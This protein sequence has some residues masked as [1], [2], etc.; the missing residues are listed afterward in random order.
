[1]KILIEGPDASGKSTLC[2]YLSKKLCIDT[3]HLTNTTPDVTEG[4]K[5][6][7]TLPENIILDRGILSSYVYSYVF[8]DT[9]IPS[10]EEI[11]IVLNKMDFIILCLPWD[12]EKYIQHFENIKSLRKEEY[13]N[14]IDVYKEFK[15]LKYIYFNRL[16]IYDI[17][18][19][20]KPKSVLNYIKRNYPSPCDEVTHLNK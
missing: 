6:Y 19:K 5:F 15:K 3:L 9:K 13:Q 7:D 14:M 4:I 10:K 18:L 17:F 16:Y 2:Q 8:K 20:Y 12:F 11:S 1:M